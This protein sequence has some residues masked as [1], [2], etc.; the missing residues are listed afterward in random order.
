MSIESSRELNGRRM[1]AICRPSRLY[2][3]IT[4]YLR[5][6]FV[7]HSHL[8][9]TGFKPGD[10]RSMRLCI[11]H[12]MMET[13]A[14]YVEVDKA[15]HYFLFHPEARKA[16]GVPPERWWRVIRCRAAGEAQ[17]E[18]EAVQDQSLSPDELEYEISVQQTRVARETLEIYRWWRDVR[19]KICAQRASIE[20]DRLLDRKELIDLLC[21]PTPLPPEI[22]RVINQ[23]ARA[24][25]GEQEKSEEML[26]RLVRIRKQLM[27]A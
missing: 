23:C 15:A 1:A 9:P 3:A 7:R 25:H 22:R 26:I 20:L 24:C 8:L 12:G 14:E 18:A 2:R 10:V 27:P 11:E 19:P 4:R 16:F 21:A 5:E 17:L 6:R 13:L